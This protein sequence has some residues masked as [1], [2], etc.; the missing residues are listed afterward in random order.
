MTSFSDNAREIRSWLAKIF[1]RRFLIA[2]G[3]VLFS[4]FFVT[5]KAEGQACM[6]HWRHCSLTFPVPDFFSIIYAGDCVSSL[7]VLDLLASNIL[8]ISRKSFCV[9]D[10]NSSLL[11]QIG[12]AIVFWFY[13]PIFSWGTAHFRLHFCLL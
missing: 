6:S 10:C 9:T 8:C 12:Q 2:A 11:L 3:L 13:V 1:L 7:S 5:A 4:K